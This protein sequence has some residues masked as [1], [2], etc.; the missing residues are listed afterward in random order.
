MDHGH[1]FHTYL[2]GLGLKKRATFNI[3][4]RQVPMAD[5][6]KEPIKELLT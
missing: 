5:P 3:G 4:G 1:L 6:A 2:G